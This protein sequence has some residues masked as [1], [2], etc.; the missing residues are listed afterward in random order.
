MI[1][2]GGSARLLMRRQSES[3]V[4]ARQVVVEDDDVDAA[5]V[6]PASEIV[7]ATGRGDDG[8]IR[9]GID[10]PSQAREHGRVVIKKGDVEHGFSV[11]HHWSPDDGVAATIGAQQ[12]PTVVTAGPGRD[13]SRSG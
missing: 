13:G 7:S 2:P 3:P 8:Q 6:E 10:Q 9:L 12:S 5:T 4:A 11:H 1:T